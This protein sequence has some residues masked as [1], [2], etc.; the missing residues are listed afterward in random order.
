V[1][2]VTSWE[3]KG[4]QIG[5]EKGRQEGRQEGAVEA[6]RSVLLDV[7]ATRFG[8]CGESVASRIRRIDSIDEL[9]AL[10]H[11]ALT[12]GSLNDLGL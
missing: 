3:R 2:Y 11:R 4:I 7:L 10:T 1:E 12:A 5:L 9:R 6:L 8:A